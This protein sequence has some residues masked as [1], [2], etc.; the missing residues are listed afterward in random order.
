M[1]NTRWATFIE[2]AVESLETGVKPSAGTSKQPSKGM[3]KHNTIW[4]VHM[5]LVLSGV[6]PPTASGHMITGFARRPKEKWKSLDLSYLILG[7]ESMKIKLSQ[8]GGIAK[9][10]RRIM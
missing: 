2:M 6:I 9:P 3:W 7:M 8:C 10:L 1:R 4:D 5:H